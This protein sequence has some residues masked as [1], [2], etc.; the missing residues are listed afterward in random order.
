MRI[1]SISGELK[2]DQAVGRDT[3]ESE[4]GEHKEFVPRSCVYGLQ[5][6]KH[7]V[8]MQ[9]NKQLDVLTALHPVSLSLCTKALRLV[10]LVLVSTLLLVCSCI[11]CSG[12]V[13]CPQVPSG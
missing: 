4:V 8:H 1:D 3:F 11:S 12:A 9:L 2:W 5:L 13:C 6:R 7:R 10:S